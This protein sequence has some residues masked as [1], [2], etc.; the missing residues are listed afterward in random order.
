MDGFAVKAR[1][2]A[3]AT[4]DAPV[5][6]KVI[7]TAPAGSASKMRLNMGHGACFHGSTLPRGWT[8]VSCKRTSMQISDDSASPFRGSA[9]F[10]KCPAAGRT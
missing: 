6:L 9:P 7:A 4:M 1:D 10:G 5:R 8:P 2:L 3:K